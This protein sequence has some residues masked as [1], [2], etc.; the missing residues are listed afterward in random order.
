MYYDYGY[1]PFMGFGIFDVIGHVFLVLLVI[2]IIFRIV[3]G[4]GRRMRGVWWSNHSALSILNERFAKG[5]IN[6]EEYED[7]KK[8]LLADTK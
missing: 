8:T 1:H 7:R 4:R 6:K 2:W 3:S 5:E